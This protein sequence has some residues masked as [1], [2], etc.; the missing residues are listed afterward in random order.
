MTSSVWETALTVVQEATP[1]FIPAGAHA[2]TVVIEYPPGDPGAPPH[3]HPGGPAFGYVIEGEMLFEL[4]GAPPRVIGP[5]EAFW[6]PGGDIIHYSDGNH[7]EDI[8]LRFV[9]TMICDPS[10]PMLV[11]VDEEELLARADRRIPSEPKA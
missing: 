10:Q 11:L 9:V 7:R 2:M 1:P 8:G 6:E 5:G 3:R 4:E